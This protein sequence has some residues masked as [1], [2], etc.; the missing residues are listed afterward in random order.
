M[1]DFKFV[2]VWPCEAE[3]GHH[4]GKLPFYSSTSQFSS[5]VTNSSVQMATA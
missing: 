1:E 3:A 5:I 4:D 2:T